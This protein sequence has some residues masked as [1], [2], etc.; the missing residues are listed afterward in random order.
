MS[1]EPS[2]ALPG[3]FNP[4]FGSKGS[5][6]KNRRLHIKCGQGSVKLQCKLSP[7]SFGVKVDGSL[8]NVD[9]QVVED[10]FICNSRND[11]S[12]CDTS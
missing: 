2:R 1:D 10:V 7:T 8:S 11:V 9:I 3:V 12:L 4:D 6:C 5:H